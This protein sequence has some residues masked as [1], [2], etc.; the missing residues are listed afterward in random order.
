MGSGRGLAPDMVD[1]GF[2]TGDGMGSTAVARGKMTDEQLEVTP[3]AQR[4]WSQA[5]SL[6]VRC[7]ERIDKT[8]DRPT[9]S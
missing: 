1:P 8:K 2:L 4:C 7:E 5:G 3:A 6:P 9:V